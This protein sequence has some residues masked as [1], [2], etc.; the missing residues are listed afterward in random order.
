MQKCANYLNSEN[1]K[2]MGLLERALTVKV[3]DIE[4]I[5]SHHPHKLLHKAN[6]K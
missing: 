1:Y 3:Q 6:T 2:K 5:F 4:A